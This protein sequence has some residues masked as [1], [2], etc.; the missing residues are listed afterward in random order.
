M[1]RSDARIVQT[2]RNG[3]CLLYLSV[4]GL[5][6]HGT[7][8]MNDAL[9]ATMYCSSCII[10][11]YAMTSSLSQY[12]LYFRIVNI[13]IYCAGS[14]ASATYA[15]HETIGIVASNL[16]LKLPFQFLGDDTL[17][18]S[19]NVGIGMRAHCRTNNVECVLRMTTP[20]AYGLRT[21]VAERHITSCDRMHFS[22][23]HTHTLHVSVLALN[24]SFTHK[25][26]ALHIHQCADCSCSHT[27]LSGSCL[28]NDACLAHL[29][30]HKNLSN[31]IIYLV[32]TRMVEVFA[33]Q[34]ELAS[35]LLA[36]TASIV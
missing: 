2:G 36:H 25:H 34:I 19:H 28:G 15:S 33:L 23:K 35:I 9:L 7:R 5:H 1:H 13:V 17:H 10:S 14:I 8:T 12:H 6:H 29:L 4:C 21:C 26:F 31:G 3:E 11:I 32:R 16:L 18:T 24:I 22:T 20:V 30:S 27:M